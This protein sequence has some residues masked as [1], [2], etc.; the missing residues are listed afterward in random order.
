MPRAPTATVV[1]SWRLPSRQSVSR[2]ELR[3]IVI[4]R[5][6]GLMAAA[7]AGIQPLRPFGRPGRTMRYQLGAPVRLS[8]TEATAST[9][10][11]R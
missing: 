1:L 10:C 2:R 3:S 8:R 5:L 4:S 11:G 6:L 7:L 9:I